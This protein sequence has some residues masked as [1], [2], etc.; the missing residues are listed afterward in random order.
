MEIK[1]AEGEGFEPPEALPPQRFSSSRTGVRIYA[2]TFV[3]ISNRNLWVRHQLPTSVRE[4]SGCRHSVAAQGTANG[5]GRCPRAY[6]GGHEIL[7]GDGH[8]SDHWRPRELT[9]G[10]HET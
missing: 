3:L 6:V 2:P 10:G 4:R 5:I 7:T 9:T 1:L 8:E